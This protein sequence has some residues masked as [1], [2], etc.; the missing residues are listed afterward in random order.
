MVSPI[1][2]HPSTEQLVQCGASILES[3]RL[4]EVEI[5]YLKDNLASGNREVNSIPSSSR[6]PIQNRLSLPQVSPIRSLSEDR[7]HVFERIGAPSEP[8]GPGDLVGS[9]PLAQRSC[10]TAANKAAGR[11]IATE[12]QATTRKRVPSSLFDGIGTKKRRVAKEQGSPK[13]RAAAGKQPAKQ[14]AKKKTIA[15]RKDAPPLP[16]IIPAI[17][18]SK[19]GFHTAKGPV[20]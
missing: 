14:V 16:T 17:T 11:R 2:Q 12:K 8:D 1:Q 10:S 13:R 3:G 5:Q 19:A 6:G 20:P 15:A 9:L 7:R 4:Q 18:R